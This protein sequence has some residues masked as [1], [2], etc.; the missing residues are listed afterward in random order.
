M[1]DLLTEL[2]WCTSYDAGAVMPGFGD[3]LPLVHGLPTGIDAV[4][5]AC[6][7]SDLVCRPRSAR[8]ARRGAGKVFYWL[9]GAAYPHPDVMLLWDGIDAVGSAA[10]GAP[11]DTGGLESVGPDGRGRTTERADDLVARYLLPIRDARL[12][13]SHVVVACFMDPADYV[14]GRPPRLRERPEESWYPGR[15]DCALVDVGPP[16]HT[17]EV[18]NDSPVPIEPELYAIVV[19]QTRVSA[20]QLRLLRARA[21]RAACDIVQCR[22][23][24]RPFERTRELIDARLRDAGVL[25]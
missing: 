5:I 21:R 2:L 13:A 4:E 1:D 22:S 8:A 24:E 3:L 25:E 20:R 18:R 19:D 9:G 14:W 16:C 12:Y 10:E 7:E 15:T 11:W 6:T 17:F 23:G